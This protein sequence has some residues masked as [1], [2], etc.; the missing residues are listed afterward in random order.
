M[1]Q[2]AVESPS[3]CRRLAR[4]SAAAPFCCP[5]NATHI[6]Q[7]TSVNREIKELLCALTSTQQPL[8]LCFACHQL[9]LR[10]TAHFPDPRQHLQG[11]C[12]QVVGP[13]DVA[14]LNLLSHRAHAAHSVTQK[15]ADAI[16][17]H[18]CTKTHT[19]RVKCQAMQRQVCWAVQARGLLMPLLAPLR[20]AGSALPP[21]PPCRA[22][23][24]G[25]SMA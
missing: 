6:A 11:P 3:K 13:H 15:Q 17:M 2:R 12:L 8:M 9:C 5:V 24:L 23:I 16:W 10:I 1:D 22:G 4:Q 18:A 7:K 21:P 19:L 14:L 25:P 20:T